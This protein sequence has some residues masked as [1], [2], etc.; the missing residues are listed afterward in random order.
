MSTLC[1]PHTPPMLLVTELLSWSEEGG[2]AL[3]HILPDNPFLLPSGLLERCA[4]AE[5]V[6]QCFAAAAGAASGAKDGFLAG[7]RDLSVIHDAMCR[8]VLT[9]TAKAEAK[10]G[11]IVSLRGSVYRAELCLSSVAL[12]VYIP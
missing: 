10:V 1:L 4:H 8:D 3:A 12:K 9:I 11:P 2:K 6:A 5:L 7:V